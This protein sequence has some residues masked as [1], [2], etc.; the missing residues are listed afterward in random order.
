MPGTTDSSGG[1]GD[2]PGFSNSSSRARRFFRGSRALLA[3]V[4]FSLALTLAAVAVLH[5]APIDP[6]PA[7]PWRAIERI[8]L[9]FGVVPDLPPEWAVDV[10]DA[11][12]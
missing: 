6:P 11:I 2:R 8:A 5:R 12:P 10:A 3:L 7:S 1:D 4:L 9:L